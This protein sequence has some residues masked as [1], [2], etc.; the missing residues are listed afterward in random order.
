MLDTTCSH[1]NRDLTSR[2]EQ[3][4]RQDSLIYTINKMLPIRDIEAANVKLAGF[5]AANYITGEKLH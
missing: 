1:L 4:A 2:V 3:K 5:L